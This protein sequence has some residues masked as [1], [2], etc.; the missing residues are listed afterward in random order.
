MTRS[1]A[2]PFHISGPSPPFEVVNVPTEAGSSPPR[3]CTTTD[4]SIRVPSITLFCEGG[5]KVGF[6]AGATSSC[7][8][9]VGCP[10]GG[11]RL[12]GL[13][14][15]CKTENGRTREAS[16]PPTIQ[17]YFLIRE[18]IIWNNL[19]NFHRR[20]GNIPCREENATA[21]YNGSHQKKQKKG[22]FRHFR[23]LYP[24]S[25]HHNLVYTG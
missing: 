14:C 19:F 20:R 2:V 4:P 25:D 17:K 8:V 3:D 13:S 12:R 9:V 18:L 23:S 7:C 10:S 24:K 15:A 21:N 22:K 1:G 11:T 16:S 5:V 6:E